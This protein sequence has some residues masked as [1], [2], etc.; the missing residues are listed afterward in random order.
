MITLEQAKKHLRVMHSLEDEL[1]QVYVT[2]A[3]A[4]FEQFSGRK[5]YAT[6]ELLAADTEAPTYTQVIDDLITSGCLLLI[7]HLYANRSED[8][9]IPRAISYCWQP[10]WVPMVS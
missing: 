9:E 3:L 5:L 6:A 1:I 7:G 10:Y 2:A 4:R 8:A